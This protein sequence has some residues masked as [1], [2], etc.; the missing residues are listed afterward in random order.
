LTSEATGPWLRLANPKNLANSGR[1]LLELE[2]GA[3]GY[4]IDW[5]RAP[6]AAS[7]PW[8]LAWAVTNACSVRRPIG[9]RGGGRS[10]FG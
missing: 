1:Y 5:S 9:A 3:D 8:G 7:H 2:I 6:K 10:P 4:E